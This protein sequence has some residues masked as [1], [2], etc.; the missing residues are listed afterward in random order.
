MGS[1]ESP[2]QPVVVYLGHFPDDGPCALCGASGGRSAWL[3]RGKI[4]QAFLCSKHSGQV[5]RDNVRVDDLFSKW[6]VSRI[7]R[8]RG[9]W[10]RSGKSPVRSDAG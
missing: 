5:P 4:L 9:L 3:C 1:R 10:G 6:G 7:V 2:D 8:P